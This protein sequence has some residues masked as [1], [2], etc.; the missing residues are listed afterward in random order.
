MRLLVL[1]VCPAAAESPQLLFAQFKS[2]WAVR[3]LALIEN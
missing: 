2:P 3:L 1:E